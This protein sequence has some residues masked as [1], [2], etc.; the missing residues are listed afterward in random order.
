[1]EAWEVELE[2]W[3]RIAGVNNVSNDEAVQPQSIGQIIKERNIKIGSPEFYDVYFPKQ[4][5]TLAM[6]AGF[7]GRV[8]K[9]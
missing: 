9:R 8:K 2:Q 7:R 6:P 1:M 4:L 5:N 3:K